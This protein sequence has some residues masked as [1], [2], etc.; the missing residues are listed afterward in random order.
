[1]FKPTLR[2]AR[3]RRPT[4]PRRAASAAAAPPRPWYYAAPFVGLTA[5]TFGLGCW[6]T[7]RYAWKQEK[8]AARAAS[9]AAAPVGLASATAAAAS[10]A[11]AAGAADVPLR[12][13]TLT[14]EWQAGRDMLV[15]LRGSPPDL[16]GP[17]PGGMASSVQ[18]FFVYSVLRLADGTEAVVNRGWLPADAASE[19]PASYAAPDG[20]GGAAV[21]VVGAVTGGERKGSFSPPNADAHKGKMLWADAPLLAKSLG[22]ASSEAAPALVLDQVAADAEPI[23]KGAWPV[24]KRRAQ[25]AGFPISSEKHQMYALTWF[26]LSAAGVVMTA[27]IMR[28]RGGG[29]SRAAASKLRQQQQ[30][31]AQSRSGGGA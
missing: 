20:G 3:A 7:Q 4:P 23:V 31:Q 2:T 18:G 8:E 11:S 12:L 25:L 9:L 17:V 5:G 29:S 19:P 13:V 6:Q 26:L 27:N 21:T 10:A 30:Q 1:M 14:G 24:P 28:G 16:L 15:G 22:V